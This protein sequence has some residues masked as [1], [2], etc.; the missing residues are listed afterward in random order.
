MV[1]PPQVKPFFIFEH[2]RA[3]GKTRQLKRPKVEQL[4]CI[5]VRIKLPDLV[6]AV[7]ASPFQV[8]RVRVFFLAFLTVFFM[9]D[10]PL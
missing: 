9:A 6:R 3:Q 5:R 10:F 1:N 2:V 7:A 8:Q 4:D